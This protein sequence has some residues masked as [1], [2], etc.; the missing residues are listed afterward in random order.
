MISFNVH[1]KPKPLSA[2]ML[3]LLMDCHERELLKQEPC[4]IG[5]SKANG[6]LNRKFVEPRKYLNS[7]GKEII[8]LYVTD[9]GRK[10]LESLK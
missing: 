10:Y 9:A 7:K 8:G 1:V 4:D 5:K 6:L 3:E 2:H